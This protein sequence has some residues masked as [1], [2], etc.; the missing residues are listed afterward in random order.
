MHRVAA[1]LHRFADRIGPGALARAIGICVLGLLV[2]SCGRVRT[3]GLIDAGPAPR[4][5][6]T[7]ERDAPFAEAGTSSYPLPGAGGKS[8]AVWTC[9][10]GGTISS[11]TGQLGL[12]VGGASASGS[13]ATPGG[14]RI[15]LGHF[16]DTVE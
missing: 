1:R 4:D 6:R 16:A 15:T 13:V 14:A 2:A 11:E 3:D 8:M 9:S 12:S 7:L 10:G 5:A